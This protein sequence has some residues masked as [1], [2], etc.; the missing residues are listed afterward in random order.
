MTTEFEEHLRVVENNSMA[1]DNLTTFET[2]VLS[3]QPA[4]EA[5]RPV[6]PYDLA[7]RRIVEGRHP[8]LINDVFQPRVVVDAGCGPTAVLSRLLAE[9]G[10]SGYG[11]DSVLQESWCADGR[12]FERFSTLDEEFSQQATWDVFKASLSHH[13]DWV[14][15]IK[16]KGDLVI[17]REV[18]EHLTLVQIRQAI[19]NLCAL[20]SKFV[21]ITTRFS[22]E[23]DL[24]RVET[25]DDLDPTHITLASKDLIRLL[26]V[27]EGFRRRADLEERMDWQKKNRVLVYERAV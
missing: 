25:H 1:A 27:L 2:L 8:Q 13:L 14:W 26:L 9:L 11:F 23:H 4:V 18:L 6:T 24:F 3:Q 7:A 17:C 12:W 16:G 22:S 21:Y 19:S 20:S 15:K 5:W 10:I